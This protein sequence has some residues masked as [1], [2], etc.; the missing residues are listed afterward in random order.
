M[1]TIPINTK[2]IFLL[3]IFASLTTMQMACRS[4]KKPLEKSVPSKQQSSKTTPTPVYA[5][6]KTTEP[7]TTS[8][9]SDANELNRR[10]E[11]YMEQQ[12]AD[13]KR[14]V[15]DAE[16]IRIKNGVQIS[17]DPGVLFNFDSA[18]L[19]PNA[20]ENIANLAVV[21]NKYKYTNILIE[22]HSDSLGTALYNQKL[23]YKRA[24]NFADY[25]IQKGIINPNRFITKGYGF[26]K[27][28]ASNKTTIGRRSNRR[29]DAFI[30]ASPELYKVLSNG[31]TGIEPS[32]KLSD[33]ESNHK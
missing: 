14:Y 19:T 18:E 29:I 22:G 2:K 3:G 6:P 4:N 15:R 24:N 12:I 10:M 11:V 1:I 26:T 16:I 31:A 25:A 5:L 8:E 21:L 33:S 28:R 32:Q 23:S 20:K 9:T 27:P 13:L 7:T 17:F 30:T